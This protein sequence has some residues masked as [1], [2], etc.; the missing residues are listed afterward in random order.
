LP[1][2]SKLPGDRGHH[3]HASDTGAITNEKRET[4]WR[5]RESEREREREGQ[6]KRERERE[7]GVRELL[8]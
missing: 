3:Q 8:G 4:R 2:A 5:D 6:R 1:V 7:C